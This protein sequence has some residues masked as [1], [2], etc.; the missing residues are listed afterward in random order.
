MRSQGSP[1]HFRF[2]SE[3]KEGG[4]LLKGSRQASDGYS[5]DLSNGDTRVSSH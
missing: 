2:C 4:G 1:Y 3:L 5:V